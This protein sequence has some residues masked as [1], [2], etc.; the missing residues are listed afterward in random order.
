MIKSLQKAQS[1]IGGNNPQLIA[2]KISFHR[3][4]FLPD[5][6]QLPYR[7]VSNEK[8]LKMLH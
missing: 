3:D 4:L 6:N 2:S 8:Q 1:K 5:H 7:P